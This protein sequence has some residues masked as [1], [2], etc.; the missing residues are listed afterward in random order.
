[1]Q[2]QAVREHRR[3]ESS[4]AS[5]FDC[6]AKCCETKCCET[7]NKQISAPEFEAFIG[8]YAA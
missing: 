8:L 2:D 7:K 1:M 3:E 5:I 4:D 6:E